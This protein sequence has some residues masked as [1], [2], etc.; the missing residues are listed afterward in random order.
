MM[1]NAAVLLTTNQ[2][3]QILWCIKKQRVLGHIDEKT[4]MCLVSKTAAR[5]KVET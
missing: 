2:E 5:I 3:M 1:Q 4:T